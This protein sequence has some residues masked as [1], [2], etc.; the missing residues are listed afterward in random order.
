[1]LDNGTAHVDDADHKAMGVMKFEDG[2]AYSRNV[3]AAKVALMLGADHQGVVADPLRHLARLGLRHDDRHRRRRR[4]AGASSTTRPRSLAADRPRERRVRPGRRGHADP[5]G[6]G[7]RGHGQRRD[8]GPAARRE[9]DRPD[10]DDARATRRSVIT[11]AALEAARGP[12]APRPQGGRLLPRPHAGPGLRGRRQDRHRPD[13]GPEEPR[14]APGRSTSSTTRS[15][16]TSGVSPGHPDLVVAVRIEEGTPTVIRLGQLEM[17]VMSFEL[18]RRIAH[19]AIS[20]PIPDPR[21]RVGPRRSRGSA[22]DHGL[23][24]TPRA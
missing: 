11:D 8:A 4:G 3:V 2:V 9:V 23:C 10:R 20:T 22:R 13:L 17:P 6:A 1:M 18:F 14:R 12:D 15:S 5:A 7:V 24:D 21:W 19:D 16:A